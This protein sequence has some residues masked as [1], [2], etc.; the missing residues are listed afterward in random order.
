MLLIDIRRYRISY[1]SGPSRPWAPSSPRWADSLNIVS[2]IVPW[3]LG[4]C[5]SIAGRLL[6]SRVF[7]PLICRASSSKAL[8]ALP[9]T[10]LLPVSKTPS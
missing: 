2:R 7:S 6:S 1:S 10:G 8:K 9:N 4:K 3:S 5:F